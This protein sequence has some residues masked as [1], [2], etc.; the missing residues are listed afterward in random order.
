MLPDRNAAV[1]GE[2]GKRIVHQPPPFLLP[3]YADTAGAFLA[4]RVDSPVTAAA[5]EGLFFRFGIERIG[6]I[7]VKIN[8]EVKNW[9]PNEDV[10]YGVRLSGFLHRKADEETFNTIINTFRRDVSVA[11]PGSQPKVR[12]VTVESNL[13]IG[14]HDKG[15]LE[16]Y[17]AEYA[18]S[19]CAPYVSQPQYA[20]KATFAVGVINI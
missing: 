2:P 6:V 10:N 19:F 8:P 9:G 12:T 20:D 15:A 18:D 1:I 4:E 17:I 14:P 3:E 13:L 16:Y 11:P 7:V 5:W